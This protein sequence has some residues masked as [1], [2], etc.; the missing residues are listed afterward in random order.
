M[1]ALRQGASQLRSNGS[2][3][4]RPGARAA[5]SRHDD[6]HGAAERPATERA[7]PADAQPE[8]GPG[9]TRTAT[10]AGSARGGWPAPND[11]RHR[12][13]HS[14]GSDC[15]VSVRGTRSDC[16]HDREVPNSA[17]AAYA[18]ARCAATSGTPA[19]DPTRCRDSA[20]NRLRSQNDPR[21]GTTGHRAPES[22]SAQGFDRCAR[23]RSD[24]EGA[25]DEPRALHAAPRI[26]AVCHHTSDSA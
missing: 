6:R 10:R 13:V 15:R 26:R 8:P 7:L 9:A 14:V 18:A 16:D 11:D 23:V 17:P 4:C 3:V 5:L 19:A 20:A 2:G 12:A 25:T 1:C 22:G 24:F 21:R